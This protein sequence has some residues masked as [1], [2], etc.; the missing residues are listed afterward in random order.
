M[1]LKI[2]RKRGGK[3]PFSLLVTLVKGR[4]GRGH[5]SRT[6]GKKKGKDCILLS[7]KLTRFVVWGERRFSYPRVAV[8]DLR[9]I[10]FGF[11][12]KGRGSQRGN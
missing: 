7:K 3:G 5:R 6:G 4:I 12:G 2:P 9:V 10:Y 8:K 1:P 11:I